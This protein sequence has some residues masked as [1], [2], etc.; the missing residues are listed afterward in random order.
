[1]PVVN[2]KLGVIAKAFPHLSL[3]KIMDELPYLGLDIEGIDRH[4]GIVKIEFNP[5]RPDFSSQNG[6]IRG[7]KGI[8]G[9]DMGVP[10]IN[11]LKHSEYTIYVDEGMQ[12]VRP[13][14]LSFAAKRPEPLTGDEIQQLIMMQE[15][16]HNGLGRKRRKSSIGIHNLDA[17]NFPLR[18]SLSDRNRKFRSLDSDED[19]SINDIFIN[20][21]TGKNYSDI[22]NNEEF[23]PLLVDS[24]NTVV[25]LPPIV[26]GSYT[27]VDTKSSELLIEVTATNVKYAK[28]MISILAYELNDMKFDLEIVSTISPYH[29]KLVSPDLTPV[30][31][32]AK[33][34]FI[35]KILGL[36]LSPQAII[37]CLEKS[38]CSGT[39]D[40]SENII[41][42]APS[43]RGDLFGSQDLCEEVIIGYGVQNLAPTYPVTNLVG[44]KDRYSKTFDKLRQVMI[45]FGFIEIL[46]TS[47]V[48]EDVV[49]SSLFNSD[50]QGDLIWVSDSEISNRS[51]LRKT[52]YPSMINT[53]STNIHEKYPQKLFEIGKVFNQEGPEIIEKWSLVASIA[54]NSTEFSEIKS[55]LESLMKFCFDSKIQTRMTNKSFLLNGHS[56][57]V[58]VNS[59][60]V[61][62]VG[63]VHPQ[64]LENFSMRT[65]VSIFEIDL[66]NIIELLEVYKH[67]SL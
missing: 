54:H 3:D 40:N 15:D 20:T 30:V 22:L 51:T 26:N 64:V 24:Q 16:L 21:E 45:G 33:V 56:A 52:L 49:E 41:C 48:G 4:A 5:N 39:L 7:L 25:S 61:G 10:T 65:L 36:D 31:I 2:V 6:I 57:L 44:E 11:S 34:S 14:I 1:M 23:V 9:T 18:Y 12:K 13:F 38:R 37:T 43:Y 66:S 17:L 19:L 32:E 42:T 29:S 27:K 8:F 58:S 67:K 46:N 62:Y 59:S 60:A 53:L 47:I 35:N 63:E 28:Q 50:S 55:T